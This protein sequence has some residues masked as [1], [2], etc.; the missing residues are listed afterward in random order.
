MQLLGKSAFLKTKVPMLAYIADEWLK[1]FPK[2]ATANTV[3]M[4]NGLS[5]II[6]TVCSLNSSQTPLKEQLEVFKA[7]KGDIPNIDTLLNCLARFNITAE[8]YC[9]TIQNWIGRTNG[10]AAAVEFEMFMVERL[11]T[12]LPI[13]FSD[14]IDEVTPIQ[15]I[16]DT[17]KKHLATIANG[18]SKISKDELATI[19]DNTL[20]DLKQ[21]VLIS[22]FNILQGELKN[23]S[24]RI[25]NLIED[26]NL[27]LPAK[28][29]INFA[30]EQSAYRKPIQYIPPTNSQVPNPNNSPNPASDAKPGS[31]ILINMVLKEQKTMK[32]IIPVSISAQI[33]LSNIKLEYID[34]KLSSTLTTKKGVTYEFKNLQFAKI[35]SAKATLKNIQCLGAEIK[36]TSLELSL[37]EIKMPTSDYGSVSGDM[38]FNLQLNT[39]SYTLQNYT[40]AVTDNGKAW[41]GF[42]LSTAGGAATAGVGIAAASNPVGW[43]GIGGLALFTAISAFGGKLTND[44]KGEPSQ[45]TIV[46]PGTQLDIT[47]KMSYNCSY[48]SENDR[49]EDRDL[50]LEIHHRGKV[51]PIKNPTLENAADNIQVSYSSDRLYLLSAK[52]H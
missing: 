36:N 47:V 5:E 40:A 18:K 17:F 23:D 35:A 24:L 26:L 46:V 1:K 19:W 38:F 44:A 28:E 42:G 45:S 11:N 21:N 37:G 10:C 43:L 20:K 6:K 41:W 4:L 49:L 50:N 3:E 14:K 2:T 30:F 13:L 34:T 16:S 32:G 29:S 48:V 9:N 39:P 12:N 31:T 15:F 52:H 22:Q 33:E 25:Y 8:P 7:G 27:Y 51:Q